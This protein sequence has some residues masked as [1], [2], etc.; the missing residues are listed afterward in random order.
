VRVVGIP[1]ETTRGVFDNF[2]QHLHSLSTQ[3][4]GVLSHFRTFSKAESSLAATQQETTEIRATSDAGSVHTQGTRL[5]QAERA[6]QMGN[7]V[8]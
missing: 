4:A 8:G 6:V 3:K 7:I 5:V 1:R 2:V